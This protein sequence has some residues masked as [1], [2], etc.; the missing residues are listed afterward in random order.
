MVKF[1]QL[2]GAL[3]FSFSNSTFDILPVNFTQNLQ[4][5]C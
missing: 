1:N 3:E 4:T 5:E 2:I